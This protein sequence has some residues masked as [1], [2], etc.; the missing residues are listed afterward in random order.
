M[1]ERSAAPRLFDILQTIEHI[2]SVTAG[3]ELTEFEADWQK[4]WLVER[5]LEIVSEASRHLSAELKARHPE[6][7]W[8]KVAGIGNVL[9][10]DYE[11][12]A[13]DILWN[14]VQGDLDPLE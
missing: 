3:I 11:R 14:L 5:G 7:P 9:R 2:R 1:A 4:Q 6:I 10:H 12:V 8:S 13:P